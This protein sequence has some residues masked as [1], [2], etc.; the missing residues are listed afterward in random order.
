MLKLSIYSYPTILGD[1]ER[2]QQPCVVNKTEE[3]GDFK[4]STNDIPLEYREKANRSGID[5]LFR[6]KVEDKKLV[7]WKFS[8]FY[9][10]S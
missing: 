6:I 3:A 7:S 8:D 4:L 1:E 2:N 10:Y 9:S 5:C